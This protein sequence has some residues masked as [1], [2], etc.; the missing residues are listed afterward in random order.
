MTSFFSPLPLPLPTSTG[1]LYTAAK[2]H[3]PWTLHC[4]IPTSWVLGWQ[5]WGSIPGCLGFFFFFFEISLC[6]TGWPGIP[7]A[8]QAGY[9][10]SAILLPLLPNCWNWRCSHYVCL[11]LCFIWL[12]LYFK[13]T[14][15]SGWDNIIGYEQCPPYS[16][17]TYSSPRALIS[18]N[19]TF[20]NRIVECAFL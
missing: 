2:Q 17:F 19:E 16:K 8:A 18:Q 11:C 3:L 7:Y 4:T 5:T 14:Q 13:V 1:S 12:L 9:E 20:S 15:L 6:S 10:L